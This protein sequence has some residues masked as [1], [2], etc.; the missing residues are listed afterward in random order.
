MDDFDLAS[1]RTELHRANDPR[2]V[3]AR[4]DLGRDRVVIELS[5]G[6]TFAFSPRRAQ[7]LENARPSDLNVIEITPSGFGLHFPKVDA[8][9]WVP[10]LLEGTFGSRRWMAAQLG[11][12]GGKVKNPAKAKA[13]RANGKLGGRPRK[14][15]PAGRPRKTKRALQRRSRRA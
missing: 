4:Y 6:D 12:Q 14:A 1:D 5:T 8:D 7:G 15:K 10:A 11:A 9:L 2:A 13:A 3:A